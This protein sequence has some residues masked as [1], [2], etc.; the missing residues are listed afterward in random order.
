MVVL[1]LQ[2]KNYNVCA[3]VCTNRYNK[4]KKVENNVLFIFL[5]L[6]RKNLQTKY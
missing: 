6:H 5:I 3:N 2:K 4:Y 1:F